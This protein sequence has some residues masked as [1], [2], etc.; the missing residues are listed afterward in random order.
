MKYRTADYGKALA[1][2]IR[3]GKAKDSDLQ[4]NF[5]GLVR[6]N[7]DEA[8]LPAI[9]AH[10]EMILRR[11]TGERKLVVESARPLSPAARKTL[12]KIIQPKDAVEEKLNP[13]L[14]AGVRITV[15]EEM[16]WDG[17]LARKIQKLFAYQ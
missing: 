11:G 7:G 14:V 15:N 3:D 8:R 12:Q 4:K 5:L 17:S 2:A 13:D 6:K 9:L 10:A 1:E 16:Q